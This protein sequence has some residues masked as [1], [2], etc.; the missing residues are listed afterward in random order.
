MP[1]FNLGGGNHKSEVAFG[2][3]IL[4]SRGE[5]AVFEDRQPK[6]IFGHRRE[7][8]KL[9]YLEIRNL[10]FSGCVVVFLLLLLLITMQYGQDRRNATM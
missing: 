6:R 1:I 3:D 10:F 5:H 2:E 8:R 7:W 9:H 4:I